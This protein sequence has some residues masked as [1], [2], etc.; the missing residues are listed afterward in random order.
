MSS[1]LL[2]KSLQL[3][4]EKGEPKRNGEQLNHT[5]NAGAFH[6]TGKTG[7]ASIASVAVNGKRI[8]GWR[9]W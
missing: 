4:E 6:L 2:R 1:S 7:I 9:F 3:F 8:A 5:G